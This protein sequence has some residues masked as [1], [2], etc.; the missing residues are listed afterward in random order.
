MVVEE[1]VVEFDFGFDGIFGVG[2]G[3]EV[4]VVG[5]FGF[6]VE[7]DGGVFDGVVLGEEVGEGFVGG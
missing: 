3:D 5:G 6:R 4:V 2:E 1:F 7:D